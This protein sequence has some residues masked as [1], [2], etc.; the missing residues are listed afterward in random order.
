[1]GLIDRT[2]RPERGAEQLTRTWRSSLALGAG[3]YGAMGISVV[4]N[5]FL[6]RRL[7]AEQWGHLALLLMA[8]Q[9]LLLV[10]VNW[11][12]AGFIRFG[13]VEFASTGGV[14]ETLS[15][16][17]GILWPVA[18]LGVLAMV[19]A[20]QPLSTYLGIPVWGVWLLLVQFVALCALSLV[21]AIFQARDQMARYSACLI[22]DKAVMLA[23]VVALPGAWTG[24]ALP[25]L[26]CYAAS[27]L[28]VAIWGVW[29]VGARALRPAR[30]SRAAYR[31]MLLF[32]APLLLTSWAGLFGTSW[33]DLVILKWYV[34]MSGIGMYV[35]AAQLAGVVQQITVVF[36]T[37]LLPE[38]SVMVA[39]G[40][41]AR[42]RLVMERLLPYW[43]LGT[44]ILFSL[45][46]LGTRAGVPLVFGQ[47]YSGA[48]PVLALFM[49]QGSALAL[50]NACTPLVTAHGS[51]WVLTG[52]AFAS[53]AVNVVMDLLLIPG[54]GIKGSALATIL[55]FGTSAVLTL[56]FVQRK[57][58]GRVLR[59]AW[60]GTPVFVVCTC[61]MLLDGVWFYPAALGMGVISVFALVGGFRLFH[62]EDMVLL[63]G[64]QLRML[65]GFGASSP[66]ERSL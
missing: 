17:L 56:A 57:T 41:H 55:A 65:F 33:F 60:L 40:Q 29:V 12:H 18:G 10:A 14:T 27:S 19:I 4:T 21:G 8:S 6:A 3:N 5:V 46:L 44:S 58:G 30:P 64:L 9:V 63:R 15:V 45:V 1:M 16:R 53:I 23:C 48:A 49:V 22:L 42:I 39:G 25:A 66:A 13:A 62:A 43:L 36:S 51:T 38:L 32:S 34:P 47:S 59:L 11:T 28:S 2:K 61:F 24:H 54:F 50:C 20:R 7:G 52:I 26:A 35:L 37:L 31:Q